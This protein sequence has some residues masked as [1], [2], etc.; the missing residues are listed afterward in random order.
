[1]LLDNDA[2]NPCFG[3]GPENPV[4]LRLQFERT[5]IGARTSLA[6]TPHMVG[7][8]NRLHSGLL[9]IAMLVT[10]RLRTRLGPRCA[11]ETA[12]WSV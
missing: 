2:A 8:P 1:M 3:C 5:P 4:G 11:A 9:D 12:N 7:W 10:T 6:V